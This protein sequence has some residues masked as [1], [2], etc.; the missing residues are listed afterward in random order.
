MLLHEKLVSGTFPPMQHPFD[1]I[2]VVLL[3]AYLKYLVYI[4]GEILEFVAQNYQATI[5]RYVL[6][7]LLGEDR[8]INL[9]D[10]SLNHLNKF[11]D[12]VCG[13]P[14]VRQLLLYHI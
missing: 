8:L 13:V 12:G 2:A 6:H 14:A 9:I 4:L 5:D 7:G 3:G 1:D 11:I 10:L